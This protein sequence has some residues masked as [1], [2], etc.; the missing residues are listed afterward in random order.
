MTGHRV[1]IEAWLNT[2]DEDGLRA[3]VVEGHRSIAYGFE[4]LDPCGAP[5]FFGALVESVREGGEPGATLVAVIRFYHD[6]A[7]LYATCGARFDVDYGRIVG[8][9]KVVEVLPSFKET[10]ES[11]SEQASADEADSSLLPSSQATGSCSQDQKVES[12]D[13]ED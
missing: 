10:A 9:G 7:E 1:V 8:T 4:N 13:S 5:M 6:L 11:P 2:A 3:P 12:C